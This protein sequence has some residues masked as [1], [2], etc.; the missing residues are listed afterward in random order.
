MRL[1]YIVDNNLIG[2]EASTSRPFTRFVYR[3]GQWL[4]KPLRAVQLRYRVPN[5]GNLLM[6]V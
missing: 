3:L 1:R 2:T 5:P 6:M 4:F